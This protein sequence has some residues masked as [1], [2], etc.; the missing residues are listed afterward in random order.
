MSMLKTDRA[1]ESRRE[2]NKREKLERIEAAGRELFAEHGYESTTTRAIAD[3]A[4]VAT[5][6][7]FVYFPGKV[8]LLI[9]LY[10]QDL[11]RILGRELD[12]LPDDLPLID[13]CM[14]VFD[15]AYDFYAE[16]MGLARSF[17]KELMFSGVGEQPKMLNTTM[18]FLNRLADLIIKAQT[19]G[20]VRKDL[21]PPLAAHQLFGTYYWG[22]VTWLGTGVVDREQLSMMTHMSLD[23]LMKGL[24]AHQD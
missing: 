18:H 16:D 6:T 3:A 24:A 15:A 2:R 5:G 8:D 19:K 14:R 11:T 1:Q 4:D 17:V 13:A 7:F 9:H 20:L 21:G 22:L 23:L 12:A 10:R